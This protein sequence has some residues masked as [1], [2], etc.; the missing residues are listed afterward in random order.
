MRM[1]RVDTVHGELRP[2]AALPRR[3]TTEQQTA[4]DVRRKKARK[5]KA[6]T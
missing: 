4:D 3:D 1:A 5:T 6:P 2:T